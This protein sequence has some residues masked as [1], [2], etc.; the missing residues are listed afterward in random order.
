MKVCV[1]ILVLFIAKITNS[2]TIHCLFDHHNED[3]TEAAS[4]NIP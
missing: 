2:H 4:K 3:L 1:F